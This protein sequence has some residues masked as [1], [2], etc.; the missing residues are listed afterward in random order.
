MNWPN[1]IIPILHYARNNG[2]NISSTPIGFSTSRRI[3]GGVWNEL[4]PRVDR[5]RLCYP[6]TRPAACCALRNAETKEQT[7]RIP[8]D[9]FSTTNKRGG[10]A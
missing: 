8:V 9:D 6:L 3:R 4:E 5:T 7:T 10:P 1:S 2:T